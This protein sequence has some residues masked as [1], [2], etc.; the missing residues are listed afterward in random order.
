[1]VPSLIAGGLVSAITTPIDTIK[2][3]IQSNK[4]SNGSI[5]AEMIRIYK[6]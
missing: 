1:M 3:R 4:T 2:T 5:I 6:T